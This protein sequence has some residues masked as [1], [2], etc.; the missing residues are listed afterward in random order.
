MRNTRPQLFTLERVHFF[1]EEESGY[2]G[3]LKG[4]DEDRLDPTTRDLLRTGR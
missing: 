1:V 2:Q 4:G 3:A